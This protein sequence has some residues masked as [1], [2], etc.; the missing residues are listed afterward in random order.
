MI[1]IFEEYSFKDTRV[2]ESSTTKEN[3]VRIILNSIE[4]F[5]DIKEYSQVKD[6]WVSTKYR[7]MEKKVRL[8]ATPLLEDSEKVLKVSSPRSEESRG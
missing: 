6:A 7:T 4:M 2:L 8:V 5:K 3:D 1:N